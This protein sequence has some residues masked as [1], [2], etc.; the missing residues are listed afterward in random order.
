MPFHNC[1]V[2]LDDGDVMAKNVTVSLDETKEGD[3]AEW[4]GTLTITHQVGL[5]A[6]QRY[7]LILDDGRRGVFVVR[8]NTFAGDIN[9]AVSIHGM[10]P[11]E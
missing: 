5:T 10:G 3:A 6:G 8:R 9:R 2:C 11:L 7:H 1:T 4:H